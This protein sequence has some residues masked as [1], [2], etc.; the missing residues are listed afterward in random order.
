MPEI[1]LSKGERFSREWL[2][3][4]NEAKYWKY[5][6]E[7]ISCVG[8]IL[9]KLICKVKLLYIKR[10]EHLIMLHSG[11]ILDLG[12]HLRIYRIYHMVYMELW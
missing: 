1:I 6:T 10:C 5:R 3:D 9:S 12:L 7:V 2:Q 8:G 11:H 4:Y